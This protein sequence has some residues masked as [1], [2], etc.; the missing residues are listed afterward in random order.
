MTILKP[1]LVI[2]L[3]LFL[4]LMQR[5][6]LHPDVLWSQCKDNVKLVGNLSSFITSKVHYIFCFFLEKFRFE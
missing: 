2:V 1:K 3:E 5:N 4:C 6:S